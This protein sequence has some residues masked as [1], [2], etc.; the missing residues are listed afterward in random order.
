MRT[1]SLSAGFV[2]SHAV[3]RNTY[4]LLSMT[5][6]WSA[7]TAL[8]GTQMVWGGGGYL[9]VVIAG[10]VMLFVTMGLRNSGWGVLAIFAFTGLEGLG[11]GPLLQA[12]LHTAHGASIIAE[13]AGTTGLTFVAL[14]GFVLITR[15]DFGFMGNFLFVGLTGIILASLMGMLFHSTAFELM[16]SAMSV[17]VFGGYV[18]FD[19]SRIVNGGERNYVMATLSLYLDILN[20]FVSLVRLLSELR[21]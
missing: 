16:I 2:E 4:A 3:L 8:L 5:L 7:V 11:L 19:T 17:L 21:D 15:K 12:Y 1:R 14:S 10:F 9:G 6:L 13:A 18:L 20:L